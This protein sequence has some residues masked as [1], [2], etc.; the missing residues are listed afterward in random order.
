MKGDDA[1]RR[2][3]ELLQD[4]SM[5]TAAT[6]IASSPDGNYLLASGVYKPRIRCYDFS[7]LSMKFERCLDAEGE[8]EEEGIMCLAVVLFLFQWLT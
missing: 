5:P 4:F 3:I 8:E 6:R 1:I 7:Q 2:R